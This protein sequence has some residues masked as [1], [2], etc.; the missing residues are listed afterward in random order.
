MLEK[1]SQHSQKALSGMPAVDALK[2]SGNLKK[3]IKEVADLLKT[4]SFLEVV[5]EKELVNAAYIESRDITKAPYLFSILKIKKEEIEVLYSIPPEIAPKKRKLDIVRYLLN[6]LSLLEQVFSIDQKTIYQL[7][8]LVT[9]EMSE[10]ITLEQ[11]KMFIVY[12][13]VKK[14]NEVLKKKI[15]RL[16]EENEALRNKHYELKG[17]YDEILL[18]IRDL[19]SLS[20]ETLKTRVQEWVSEHQ[21]EIN[22]YEFC[23]VY[24]VSETRVEEILNKLVSEG[25]LELAE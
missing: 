8:E 10:D 15:E 13:T 1:P 21:G 7:I 5:Q 4:I 22:V 11:S 24:K 3:S 12:D 25:Y 19:E 9:R 16:N 18:R 14:E 17:K 2:I 6:I 20:D 23:K